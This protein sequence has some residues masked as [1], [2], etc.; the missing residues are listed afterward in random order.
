MCVNSVFRINIRIFHRTINAIIED[1][2]SKYVQLLYLS[3]L[4]T[5]DVPMR[6]HNQIVNFLETIIPGLRSNH[7]IR[8]KSDFFREKKVLK[9]TGCPLLP[10]RDNDHHILTRK[11]FICFMIHC[12]YVNVRVRNFIIDLP[13]VHVSFH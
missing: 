4:C 1:P 5:S 12:I 11:R 2:M 10:F 7:S 6:V 13:S 8:I 3:Y 9:D